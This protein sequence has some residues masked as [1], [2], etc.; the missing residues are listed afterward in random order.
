MACNAGSDGIAGGYGPSLSNTPPWCWKLRHRPRAGLS[1]LSLLKG[2]DLPVATRVSA[3]GEEG[4][5]TVRESL[6]NV[7]AE[8]ASFEKVNEK[9]QELMI[10]WVATMVKETP[11]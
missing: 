7:D 9:V 3:Q 1:N 10:A 11:K 5:L 4:I 2:G 8:T 6:C